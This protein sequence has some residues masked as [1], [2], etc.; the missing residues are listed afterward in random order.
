MIKKIEIKNFK[1]IRNLTLFCNDRFNV[2]I[3]ENS[4]GKTS[5]FEAIHLWK[6][7]Y[8]SHIKKDK[9]GFY[10]N[11]QNIP[12][13]EMEYIRVYSDRDLFP[14]GCHITKTIICICLTIEFEGECFALGFNISKVGNIDDAY[15]HVDYQSYDEFNR[16]SEKVAECENYNLSNFIVINESRPIAN[17]VVKEPYMYKA[18]V[19]DKIKRGKGYEVLRNKIARTEEKLHNVEEHLRRVFETE[20]RFNEVDKENRT[21]IKLNVNGTDILS[22]GSGFLQV[23]EIFSSLE[24]VNAGIN[25]LLI[26]EPDSHLHVRIQKKLIEELRSIQNSQLFVITHNERFLADICEDELRFITQQSNDGVEVNSLPQG[27]KG[28]VMENLVGTLEKIEVLRY[29]QNIVLLEGNG[30]KNFFDNLIPIYEGL[31]GEHL[32][33]YFIDVM[34]GIDTLQTKLLIYSRAVKDVVQENA[35]WTVIRD[36]DCLPEDKKEKAKNENFKEFHVSHKQ[37]IFQNGYG[38]ESTFVS[39]P[40]KFAKILIHYYNLD[41]SKTEDIINII[42]SLKDSYAERV[43]NVTDEINKKFE[44]HY[45]RQK[46]NRKE[47]VYKDFNLRD[48]LRQINSSNIQNIMTK[49]ILDMYLEEVHAAIHSNICSISKS[50]LEG[51]GK[52]YPFYASIGYMTFDNRKHKNID[53]L[54]KDCDRKMIKS[55]KAELM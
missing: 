17:I 42:I 23:A 13:R 11:N 38:I 29:A 18:Q 2:L 52:P 20:I 50:K 55:R 44:K 47:K 7:C 10:S 16:F 22:Q 46:E 5:I 6:I 8:D 1:S 9:K 36:T 27:S 53:D 32:Q 40:N 4:I 37:M 43:K 26:D 41:V 34:S 14:R 48:V 45:N 30:D 39:E 25:I 31:S 49:E 19:M 35:K 21:Y 15:L 33:G 51:K 24:Y 28:I 12:F 54:I 3:G